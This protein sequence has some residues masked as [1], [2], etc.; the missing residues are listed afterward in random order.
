METM[1]GTKSTRRFPTRLRSSALRDGNTYKIET[2]RLN[3]P[4]NMRLLNL[5]PKNCSPIVSF[6]LMRKIKFSKLRSKNLALKIGWRSRST[7]LK[8]SADSAARDGS[9]SCSRISIQ[10]SGLRLKIPCYCKYTAKLAPSGRK[11]QKWKNSK[12]G[13]FCK[14]RIDSIR[15]WKRETKK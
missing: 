4:P 8:E 10:A 13:P 5:Y 2:L 6:G 14:S 15:L 11:C 1:L 9:T 7:F 3:R 12:V